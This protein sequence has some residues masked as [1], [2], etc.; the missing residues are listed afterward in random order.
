[1]NNEYDLI[2][3]LVLHAVENATRHTIP[4]RADVYEAAALVLHG[5]EAAEASA[6]A[7]LLRRADEAQLKF[8]TI[9]K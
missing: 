3:K 8:S 1:M 5:E 4:E 2:K 7:A 6:T 9:L